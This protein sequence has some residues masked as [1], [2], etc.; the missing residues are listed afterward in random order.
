MDVTD[1]PSAHWKFRPGGYLALI[2]EGPMRRNARSRRS[3]RRV[4]SSG[5]QGTPASAL[6]IRCR[7]ERGLHVHRIGEGIPSYPDRPQAIP[8]HG[9]EHR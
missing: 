2:L 3:Q 7:R 9:G 1:P 8:V 4:P 5:H 6:R